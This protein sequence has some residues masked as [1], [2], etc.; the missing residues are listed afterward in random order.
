[1]SGKNPSISNFQIRYFNPKTKNFYYHG[2]ESVSDPE[3]D[4][5]NSIL[6]GEPEHFL[7]PAVNEDKDKNHDYVDSFLHHHHAVRS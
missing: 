7:Y 2:I 3:S 6:A 1:M 5:K 4:N